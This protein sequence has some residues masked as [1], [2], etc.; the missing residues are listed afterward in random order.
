MT[1]SPKFGRLPFE[2]V[3][4]PQGVGEFDLA[5]A[6]EIE[7]THKARKFIV[8]EELGDDGRF[9]EGGVLDYEG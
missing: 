6:V 1:K 2:L 3:I 7:L 9:E 5:E 4:D 8:F